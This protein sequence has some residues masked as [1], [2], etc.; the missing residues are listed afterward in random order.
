MDKGKVYFVGAGVG[1]FELLTLKGKRY[2]EMADCVIYDR[3]LNKNILSF[4]NSSATLIY[5][6]KENTQ[7]GVLQD[8]I[9]KTLIEKA[10]CGKY[11]N[12][13]RLKG[14]DS[15]V[16]GRGGEEIEAL[17]RYKIDYEIV[18]GISS[19]IA[20]PEYSGIPVTHRNL[21]RSFHVF[22]GM[23][24]NGELQDFEI[25]AKLKGTLVFLMGV[26]NL[27]IICSN[28]I[29]YGKDKNTPVA[30]I[31]N[32]C[33]PEQKTIAG[34][35]ENICT[36]ATSIKPPAIIVVGEV[37]AKRELYK[38]FENK[39]LF[40][41][42]ILITREKSKGESLVMEIE[43]RG[44]KGILLPMIKLQDKMQDFNFSELKNYQAIMFNSPNGVQYF[45]EHIPDI[46][47]IS[48]LKIGVIGSKTYE[49]IKKYKIIPD[50]MPNEY[51]SEKLA[52]KMCEFTQK[53]DNILVVTSDVSPFDEKIFSKQYERNFKKLIGYTNSPCDIN[54][55]E[56]IKK[57]KKC[58][59]ITFFSG[60]AV[61]NFFDILK[62]EKDILNGIKILSIGPSTTKKIKNFI[63][64]PII[65]CQTY[66]GDE[67]LKNLEIF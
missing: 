17:N 57:I 31:Q 20:V 19:S 67:I 15:F 49:E 3:L 24:A 18:P 47:M 6:G 42:N 37:V 40:G 60:S 45:F 25:I 44:G 26:K 10:T 28:L 4:V 21:A 34:T 54:Y 56:F 50:C 52:K 51:L 9:N 35:L 38:W 1:D 41:K 8:E 5:L 36:L 13:V 66:T 16:F 62:E 59:Y 29:K 11:K 43:R 32:G 14:G 7:G 61:D 33:S 12:I 46:R 58:E 64:Y 39:P 48:N 65:E 2:L 55:E 22:T 63:D 23:T 30:I 53:N 27:N